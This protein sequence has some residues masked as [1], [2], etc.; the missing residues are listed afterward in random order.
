MKLKWVFH[1]A[2]QMILQQQFLV[3]LYFQAL[4]LRHTRIENAHDQ[5]FKW[6]FQTPGKKQRG[7][8]PKMRFLAWLQSG[9]GIFWISGKPGSGKST[10]MKY[11]TGN[12]YT[13]KALSEWANPETT[14]ITPEEDN[15]APSVTFFSRHKAEESDDAP[16]DVGI[17]AGDGQDDLHDAG[18]D[19]VEEV[20]VVTASFYF[21]SAGTSMQKSQQGLFQSLLYEIF[22][23]APDLMQVSCPTRWQATERGE[24]QEP[25]TI[26]E[27]TDTIKRTIS[28]GTDSVK[29]CFFVDG[30]DEY[31][32]DHHEMVQLLES[33][34]HLPNVKLCVS[35][36]PWNVFE[37]AFGQDSE[38]KFYLQDLT[39]GDIDRYVRSKLRQHPARKALPHDN[40]LYKAI[41]TE[42][43]EKAQGVF[44][45]VFLVVRSLLEGL[46]NGDTL[47]LLQDRLRWIPTDLRE[48]FKYMLDSL[49][50]IYNQRVAHFF[51]AALDSSEPLLLMAYSY[52]D[53]EFDDAN[54]VFEL[55]NNP[56]ELYDIILR[57]KQ[58]E[59]RLNGRCKGLLET[60]RDTEGVDFFRYRVG[61]LHRTVRDFFST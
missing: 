47:S 23:H 14:Q 52:F 56:P 5:T 26:Q 22:S 17:E 2:S 29:F 46:S 28:L 33:F 9:D 38:R 54:Y 53:E 25:W 20:R 11:I 16:A 13:K 3:S 42:I 49:D 30:V 55:D 50:P 10:L 1:F 59:R 45:W 4:K 44:L 31:I 36:R 12:P 27:I 34:A 40:N 51:L 24:S 32:G 43:I 41:I 6:L 37:D 21:W 18:R 39:R 35:S 15:T 7:I 60:Y 61:F 19:F 48:F 57:H 58:T 8:D